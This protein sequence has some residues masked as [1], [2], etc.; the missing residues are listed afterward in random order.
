MAYFYLDL[1]DVDK[2]KLQDLL[3]SFLIQVSARSDTRCGVL[4]QLYSS[5]DWGIRK[6]HDRIV[7][8][9]LEEMLAL[10]TQGL[11]YNI[12][13]TIDEYPLIS[14]VPSPQEVFELVEELVGLHIPGVHISVTSRPELDIQ[15]FLEPLTS[16]PVSLHDGTGQKQDIADYLR[17]FVHGDRRMQR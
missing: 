2:Q 9:C 5:H 4:S 1:K 10:D 14:G 6:P 7:I 16:H 13:D 11:T 3:P 12:I 17:T 8:K 15:T